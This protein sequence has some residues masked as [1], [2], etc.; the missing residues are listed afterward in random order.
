M[1][2]LRLVTYC[3][4]YCG[5]CAQHARIPDRAKAL[6]ESMAKEGYEYWGGGIPGFNEFWGF[7]KRVSESHGAC[8]CR[9]GGGYPACPIR[10][11]ARERNI[12]ICTQCGDYPCSHVEALAKRYWFLIADGK[13]MQ[14]I[15][16]DA[17]ITEQAERA[18]TGFAYVDIR[19][20]A[21]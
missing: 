4:L 3:G 20:E 17:W 2:Q 18:K 5:L 13:R 14:E 6:R 19:C 21:G 11:C 8:T 7:L 10:V 12:E 16:L 9:T 1:D 15:G